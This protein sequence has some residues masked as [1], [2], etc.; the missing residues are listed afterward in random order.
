MMEF[1]DFRVLCDI[2]STIPA[3][4]PRAAQQRLPKQK[5]KKS[6]GKET[7]SWELEIVKWDGIL[8]HL[9]VE[10]V[11]P[12]MRYRA[13]AEPWTR[14]RTWRGKMK[15]SMKGEMVEENTKSSPVIGEE[16]RDEP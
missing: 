9:E 16:H 8:E 13:C 1:S 15:N 5:W 6:N 10:A 12:Q 14:G 7:I 4:L 11:G 3:V 2:T